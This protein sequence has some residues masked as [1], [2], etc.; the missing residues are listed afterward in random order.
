MK[1]NN[2]RRWGTT[3]TRRPGHPKPDGA[4][5]VEAVL[6]LPLLLL[7]V[8]G[9]VEYAFSFHV[10]HAMTNAARDAA[11]QL[12]VRGS[13]VAQA[14]A[15]VLDR[16]SHIDANFTVTAIQPGPGSTNRDVTI[17]ITVPRSEISLGLN[18]LLPPPSGNTLHTEVTMR[19]EGD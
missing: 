17:R 12:A 18:L 13:T 1:T 8:F 7:V 5:T 3:L 9:A 11:R 4:A 15:V 16:L 10:L 19:K 2:V 14:Q 6:V